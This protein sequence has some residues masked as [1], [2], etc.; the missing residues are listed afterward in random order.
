ME[1][2]RKKYPFGFYICALSFSFER[3]A[4]Y[5]GKWILTVFVALE[6][7]KGGLGLSSAQGAVFNSYLM[8]FTYI[9]PLL[10]GYIADRYI[11]PRILIPVGEIL[12]GLGY[13]CAWQAHG[14]GMVWAMIILVSIGTGFFKGNLSGINGR[15]FDD[16]SILDSAFCIQYSFVNAGA[17]LGTSV[18]SVLA[19]STGYRQALLICGILMFVD[20][21]WWIFGQKS[22]G[23]AGKKPFLIDNRNTVSKHVSTPQTETVQADTTKK[24]LTSNEKKRVAAII[25][26]TGFSIIFWIMWNLLYL[27]AYYQFGPAEQGGMGWAN[28]NIGNFQIPTAWYDSMNA[29]CCIAFGPVLAAVWTKLSK[30]KSGDISMFKKTAL[31]MIILG[32]GIVVLVVAS[33]MSN[34]GAHPV[35]VWMVALVSALAALGEMTFSPLGNSFINKFAPKRLLGTLLG[36]WPVAGF[37]SGLVYG[38]LYNWLGN[39]RFS[40]AYS[41]VATVVILCGVILWALSGSFERLAS[42]DEVE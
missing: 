20:V 11:S 19:L 8:A 3:F 26:V 7:V 36:V 21:I 32:I 5:A 39:F 4:Y 15:L 1:N 38:H 31:G 35:G 12:M 22:L 23:D 18:M 9:T 28:W 29:L 34:E 14:K 16:P 24:A 25:L 33:I 30:R 13:L 10:G 2:S 27:P 41:V 42:E 40:Y 6:T 37:F 17:F